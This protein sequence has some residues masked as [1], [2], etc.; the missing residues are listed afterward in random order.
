VWT[1]NSRAE[2]AERQAAQWRWAS[3][4]SVVHHDVHSAVRGSGGGDD[5]LHV[6]WRRNRADASNGLAAGGHDLMSDGLGERD[7]SRVT[8][9][10]DDDH[11]SP[12]FG[13]EDGVGAPKAAPGAGHDGLGTVE[14]QFIHQAP[15]RVVGGT[16]QPDGAAYG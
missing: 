7:V 13:E 6:G 3:N 11:P 15:P 4:A 16:R 12:A 14:A 9:D 2:R 8:A 5:P 10:V 1:A